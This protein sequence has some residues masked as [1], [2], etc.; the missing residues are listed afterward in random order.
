MWHDLTRVVRVWS[1]RRA[2][3]WSLDDPDEPLGRGGRLR[4]MVRMTRTGWRWRGVYSGGT[5]FVVGDFL[6]AEAALL[7]ATETTSKE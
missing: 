5:G 7:A 6:D 2:T 1:G 3:V 4:G